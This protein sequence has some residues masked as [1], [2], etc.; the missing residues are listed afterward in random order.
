MRVKTAF[1]VVNFITANNKTNVLK[2]TL[3]KKKKK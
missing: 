1:S 3:K 2:Y